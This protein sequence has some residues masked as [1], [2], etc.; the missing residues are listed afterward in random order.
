MSPHHRGDLAAGATVLCR[1]DD[2]RDE[3]EERDEGRVHKVLRDRRAD[4]SEPELDRLCQTGSA[5]A[6]Y[7]FGPT[8]DADLLVQA[9]GEEEEEQAGEEEGR[10]ADE[11]KEVE[12]RTPQAAAD[13]LL[14]DEG[15]EGQHLWVKHN[16]S[17]MKTTAS[18][19]RSKHHSSFNSTN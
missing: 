9:G 17:L 13:G 11:L 14:Q 4:G 2:G 19:G 15:H 16:L 8:A 12:R 5:A 6:S 1:K 10:A 3:E 18:S 7:H